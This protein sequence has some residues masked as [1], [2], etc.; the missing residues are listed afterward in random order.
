[1]GRAHEQLSSAHGHGDP[2]GSPDQG[3]RSAAVTRCQPA[4]TSV[5][6]EQTLDR[7]AAIRSKGEGPGD[8][9][10][11]GGHPH[12][13]DDRHRFG[14]L[15]R[16]VPRDEPTGAAHREQEAREDRSCPTDAAEDQLSLGWSPAGA[17]GP[18]QREASSP[19]RRLRGHRGSRSSGDRPARTV[20]PVDSPLTGPTR[21]AELLTMTCP[22]IRLTNKG[23]LSCSASSRPERN[24]SAAARRPSTA[25]VTVQQMAA[26]QQSTA[27]TARRRPDRGGPPTGW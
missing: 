24:C 18:L 1:M 17:R 3:R 13:L 25:V 12:Q 22:L 2:L 11:D 20:R 14:E 27:G 9:G 4:P 16:R 8:P 19:A 21:W 23:R 10:D 26:R 6:I 5:T 7:S 15:P